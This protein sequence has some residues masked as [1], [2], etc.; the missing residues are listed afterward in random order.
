LWDEDGKKRI[1]KDYKDGKLEY[2]WTIHYG[3]HD[4][5]KQKSVGSYRK[6]KSGKFIKRGKWTYYYEN[7][8]INSEDN[9]KDSKKDGLSTWWYENG[10]KKNE[11]TF[12]DG[13]KDGLWTFW[14][15]NGLKIAEINFKD[16][17][18]LSRKILE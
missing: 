16:G 2:E 18:E 3:Y 7:G 8:Q 6:D 11:G 9:L 13:K 17:K 1:E 14:Y 5:G 15:E 4:N 10:Q 12:K